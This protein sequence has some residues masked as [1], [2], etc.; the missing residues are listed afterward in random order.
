MAGQ[1]K[2]SY[3][4]VYSKTDEL[5]NHI[6]AEISNMEANC[7]QV[8]SMLERVDGATNAALK[9]AMEAN[10]A[11]TLIAAQTLDKLLAFMENSSKQVE[12]TEQKIKGLF[13]ALVG[14]FKGGKS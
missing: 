9:A 4:D 1:I 11:K 8:L 14:L 7:Q 6:A 3:G 2:I 5:K 13:D 12:T 10:K